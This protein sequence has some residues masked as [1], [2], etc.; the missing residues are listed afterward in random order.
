[1]LL[2]GL[3]LWSASASPCRRR[4]PLC[5]LE[6]ETVRIWAVSPASASTNRRAPAAA[7]PVLVVVLES[8]RSSVSV[9]DIRSLHLVWSF[10]MSLLHG[11]LTGVHCD[12]ESGWELASARDAY[13]HAL[14]ASCS[15]RRLA[16][17]R[18]GCASRAA[19]A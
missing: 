17:E 16:L 6:T 11:L 5:F 13:N 15:L 18:T 4:S 2:G 7:L 8:W 19:S 9:L 10:A 3:F 12:M 14:E 1:M